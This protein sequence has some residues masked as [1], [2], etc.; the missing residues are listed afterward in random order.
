MMAIK[1]TFEFKGG[2][3]RPWYEE[4]SLTDLELMFLKRLMGIEQRYISFLE[5]EGDFFHAF[6]EYR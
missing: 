2:K 6:E 5:V 4:L 3:K 1:L